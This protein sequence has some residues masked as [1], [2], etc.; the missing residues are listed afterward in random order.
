M[1]NAK[2]K[3]QSFRTTFFSFSEAVKILYTRQDFAN[4]APNVS[5]KPTVNAT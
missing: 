4:N 3:K 1:N 5:V 2:K